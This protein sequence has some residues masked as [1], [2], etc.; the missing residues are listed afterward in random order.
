MTF[1]IS[2][3]FIA[4]SPR[5]ALFS[6]WYAIITKKADLLFFYRLDAIIILQCAPRRK[7]H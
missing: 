2:A 7:L 4:Y 6:S 5:L 1:Y 3:D